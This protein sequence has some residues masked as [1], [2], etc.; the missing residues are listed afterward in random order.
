ME[1]REIIRHSFTVSTTIQERALIA[2][3]WCHFAYIGTRGGRS[4]LSYC[5]FPVGQSDKVTRILSKRKWNI[6]DTSNVPCSDTTNYLIALKSGE[7]SFPIGLSN[8]L[9]KRE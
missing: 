4:G 9:K 8:V 5:R 7:M 2:A 3:L 1:R 6:R